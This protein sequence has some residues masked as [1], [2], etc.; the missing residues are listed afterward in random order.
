MLTNP[1]LKLRAASP[2]RILV[3]EDEAIVAMALE[4]MLLSLGYQVVGPAARL[5]DALALAEASEMDGAILDVNLDGQLSHEVADRL[6][7]RGVPVLFA[8]GYGHG[9]SASHADTPVLTKP[10]RIDDLERALEQLL[11]R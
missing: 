4:D 8:T 10:Y 2:P 1:E 7:A 5:A 11:P 9:L 6:R 3:V